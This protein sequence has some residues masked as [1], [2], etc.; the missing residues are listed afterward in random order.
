M[1]S[2]SSRPDRQD[3]DVVGERIIA[4]I[5]DVV[6]M[7]IQLFAVL[8]FLTAV[9]DTPGPIAF[10]LGLASLPLY[11]GLFEGYWNGQTP[12]KRI[13]DIRVVDVHGSDCSPGQGF[14]R[15]LPAALMPGWP[16][17]LVA[18]ACMA[19][20]DRRQRLFDLLVGTVVVN[21]RAL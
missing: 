14:A 1:P 21:A 11:G 4:Q 6:L 16:V 9:L 17:Y 18:L 12:G 19:M 3:T 5:L 8:F 15:N 20:T 7:T 2:E 10:L 13:V